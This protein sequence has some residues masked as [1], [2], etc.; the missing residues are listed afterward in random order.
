MSWDRDQKERLRNAARGDTMLQEVLDRV[1]QRLVKQYGDVT[2][3]NQTEFAPKVGVHQATISSWI[4]HATRPRASKAYLPSARA[5]LLL[6]E[7]LGVNSAWLFYGIGAPTDDVEGRQE[8]R[9][10]VARGY[11]RALWDLRDWLESREAETSSQIARSP[12]AEVADTIELH[13][14]VALPIPKEGGGEPTRP[15]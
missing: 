7:A 2:G 14:E 9:Q 3:I 8:S 11:L 12:V 5:L 15:A 13:K 4:A 1:V 10:T 6:P